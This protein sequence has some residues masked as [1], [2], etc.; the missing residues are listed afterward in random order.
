MIPLVIGSNPDSPWI[1]NWSPRSVGKRDVHVHRTGGY[2]LA[3]LRSA[4][5]R[6]FL[7]LQDSTEIRHPHFWDVIDG[8]T[9]PA[10][11]FGWPGSYLAVYDRNDLTPLLD[12]APDP[13][14][15]EQSIHWEARFRRTLNYPTLWP[16]VVDATG[17]IEDRHG[18][19]NLVLENRYLRKW[20]GTWR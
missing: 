9:G 8:L 14:D 17:R 5:F 11:L 6:R 10:W 12:E 1:G 3:A 2:E 16:D 7:F 19:S 4:P 13:V 20:K 15:K 18:R